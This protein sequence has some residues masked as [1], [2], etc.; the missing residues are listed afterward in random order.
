MRSQRPIVKIVPGAVP[1]DR[2]TGLSSAQPINPSSAHRQD[3][4]QPND[5]PHVLKRLLN[6]VLA[7]LSVLAIAASLWNLH[8]TT[9]GLDVQSITI[10]DTPATIYRSSPP[11]P[12]AVIV[13]AHGFAGSQQLMQPF[14][15]T[16][17][18][19]GYIAVTFD[20]RGHGRNPTP[21]G[22]S[23]TEITG[24]TRT[25]AAQTTEVLS[26][27]RTLGDGRLAILGHSMASDIVVRVAQAQP[28]IAATIAVSMFS[29]AVTADTP[30]NLLVITGAWEGRL[31]T[32]ALRAVGLATA[33]VPAVPATTT[34]D[35]AAGTARRAA[36]SPHAEH[37]SVLY[38]QASMAEALAW[39]DATFGTTRTAAPYLDA[40]GP[41][42]LLLLAGIV[43]LGRPLSTLL[44]EVAERRAGAALGW[45]QLAP[46]LLVPTIATPLLLR[47]IPTHFLP[48]LVADYLAVHFAVYGALTACCLAWIH[49]QRPAI[50]AGT[51]VPKLLASSAL[52]TL[53]AVGLLFWAIDTY[54]TSFLPSPGRAP[55]LAAMLIGT[56]AFFLSTEWL[57]RG[58]HAARG[59]YV[60]AKAA[61]IVSLAIAV[62]LD[63]ERLFFLI[64]I[65]PLIVVFFVIYGLISDWVYRSTRHPVVAG[66]ATA[67][68]FACAIGVTFPL[69]AG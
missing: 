68:A 34:G 12:S 59:G 61:F 66:I 11:R 35:F 30:R 15:V 64:I 51:S 37:I 65:V 29:P 32:E 19:A 25:L 49:R 36:F 38:N 8:A 23:I 39:L 42:I 3:H 16:F 57:T 60:A 5:P 54:V 41:W 20:F 2:R 6:P 33:P 55:L 24:A 48:V 40:R 47:F 7:I 10:G 31:K 27:A 43:A 46:V 21:L 4:D 22:G 14:A 45:R 63:F 53:Y 9:A 17:A 62:A 67:I 13:I 52:V 1:L 50:P 69:L 18:R 44:P 28:D 26:F 56:L 58:Q